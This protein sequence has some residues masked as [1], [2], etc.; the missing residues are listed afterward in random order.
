MTDQRGESHP[1]S[2]SGEPR[3]PALPRLFLREPGWRVGLK[4]GNEREFCYATVPGQDYYHRLLE[5]EVY[6]YHGEEKLCLPCADRRGLLDH[7][8]RRLGVPVVAAGVE[9]PEG[10][11]D[12][13]LGPPRF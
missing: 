2:R 13:D 7:E 6:L 12:Y 8:P 10:P 5:G 1:D 4:A 3:G 11:S 9:Q